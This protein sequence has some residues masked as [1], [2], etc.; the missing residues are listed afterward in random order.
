MIENHA[1]NSL[2]EHYA[3]ALD[4]W[5][6]AGV[7]YVFKDEVQALLSQNKAAPAKAMPTAGAGVEEAQPVA[8]DPD[9]TESDLP[10]DL[11]AFQKW[12]MEAEALSSGP[13]ARI[14][15]R[16]NVGAPLMF[17]VPIPEVDDREQLL[18]GPQGRMLTNIARALGV[19]ADAPYFTSAL[20]SAITLP[21]WDG[22]AAN[23][24]G[25]ALHRHIALAKP[26]RVVILG[27]KLPALLGHD[28]SAPPETFTEIAGIPA[29]AT[30]APERLLDHPRQRARLWHRLLE[31]TA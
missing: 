2:A 27:S 12:W 5:R 24:L 29:L 16:G 11:V 1:D 15:P 28:A 6:D 10:D 7:D 20:P 17:L 4:W 23:G 25:A 19:S 31:W 9:I 13:S 21:D 22:F 3:A 14:A 18:A 8:V 26:E 30:F